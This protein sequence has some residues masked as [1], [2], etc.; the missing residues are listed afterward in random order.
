MKSLRNATRAC[1][2]AAYHAIT[3][4]KLAV[5]R[6]TWANFWG[7]IRCD[8]AGRVRVAVV[9]VLIASSI[10]G[11]DRVIVSRN[12]GPCRRC[13]RR[14]E[15][16][17]D[18]DPSQYAG[19]LVLFSTRLLPHGLALGVALLAGFA[20]AQPADIVRARQ[21]L[22]EARTVAEKE[23]DPDPRKWMVGQ[24]AGDTLREIALRRAQ[25]SD[26]KGALRAIREI[27]FSP[28]GAR[29]YAALAEA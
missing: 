2:T 19:H 18:Q 26:F 4:S 21:L 16:F 8:D 10:C 22:A 20:S 24:V 27:G 28:M 1:S 5:L 9:R 17:S 13:R 25:R 14:R 23:S 7:E 12:L 29:A 3:A 11:V 6:T 15:S